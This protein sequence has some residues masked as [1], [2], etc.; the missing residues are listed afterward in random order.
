LN[1]LT[2]LLEAINCVDLAQE[3]CANISGNGKSEN[4]TG[5][6]IIAQ[7]SLVDAGLCTISELGLPVL[8]EDFAQAVFPL[9]KSDSMV[10]ISG[11]MGGP[12]EETAIYMV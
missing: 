3:I 10:P 7:Q 12:L 11:T 5:Q 1:E 6:L 8:I 4:Y 9:A 2:I